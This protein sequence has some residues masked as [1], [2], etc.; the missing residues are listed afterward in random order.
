[1]HTTPS[2]AGKQPGQDVES[3]AARMAA[4]QRGTRTG[5]QRPV[6]NQEGQES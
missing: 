3:A 2:E 5:R 1:V 6:T 4:L